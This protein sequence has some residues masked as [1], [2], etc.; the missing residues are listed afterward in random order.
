MLLSVSIIFSYSCRIFH[1][2]LCLIYLW[3]IETVVVFFLVPINFFIF[4]QNA[5]LLLDEY[6]IVL[7]S[8]DSI[9]PVGILHPSGFHV[10]QKLKAEPLNE[11]ED[12]SR[13]NGVSS[14]SMDSVYEVQGDCTQSSDADCSSIDKVFDFVTQGHHT[15]HVSEMVN[16]N[17]HSISCSLQN[18]NGTEG[19]K[20]YV[21]IK[22]V[23]LFYMMCYLEF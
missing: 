2:L 19:G 9:A 3:F 22:P 18:L 12:D 15:F 16:N 21:I 5:R 23:L 4:D 11:S 6:Q 13:A 1:D 8:S 14:E 20:V 17:M 10:E 7:H